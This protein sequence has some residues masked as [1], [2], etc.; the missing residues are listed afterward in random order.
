MG[1]VPAGAARRLISRLEP[2]PRGRYAGPVGYVDAAGDGRWM[3][4]IRAMTVDDRTARLTAGVGIVAGSDPSTELARGQLKFT[5]VFDALAPGRPCPTRQGPPA[6]PGGRAGRG[7]AS[8]HTPDRGRPLRAR[9]RLTAA[10]DTAARRA[11]R[12][13]SASPSG[14]SRATKWPARGSSISSAPGMAAGQADRRPGAGRRRPTRPATTATGSASPP[15]AAVTAGSLVD[16]R[17]LLDHERPPVAARAR[18]GSPAQHP[19]VGQRRGQLVPVARAGTYRVEAPD[20]GQ[21]LAD[22]DQAGHGQDVA[23]APGR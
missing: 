20:P 6:T 5:A 7:Q 23:H 15:R 2:E 8:R 10:S 21:H 22:A 4:G 1:G 12:I 14:S 13:T 18:R 9:R 11:D 16:E 17:P 19:L 3:L